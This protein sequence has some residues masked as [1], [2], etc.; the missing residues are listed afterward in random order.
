MTITE[1]DV[2]V[3]MPDGVVLTTDIQHPDGQGPFPT[4]LMRTCYDKNVLGAYMGLDAFVEAGYRVVV[5][6]CRG[7]GGS[8]GEQD[9]FAGA[10][11]R[12]RDRRLDRRPTLVRRSARD[13]R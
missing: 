6:D 13:F 4:L 2:P 8:G 1:R 5:Q 10:R 11:R 3:E 12:A 7:S 9:H